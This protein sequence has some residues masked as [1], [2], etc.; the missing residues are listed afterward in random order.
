MQFK[1][2]LFASLISFILVTMELSSVKC[3]VI[4]DDQM[5]QSINLNQK[6]FSLPSNTEFGMKVRP[7]RALIFRPL[8]VYK[9]QEIKKQKRKEEREKR[10]QQQG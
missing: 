4:K 3:G 5:I 7:R 6:V 9:E 1:N 10:R 2:I 8:F